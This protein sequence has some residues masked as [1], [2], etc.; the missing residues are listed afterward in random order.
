MKVCNKAKYVL[1]RIYRATN[2]KAYLTKA[3]NMYRVFSIGNKPWSFSWDDKRAGVQLMLAELT[4]K[5]IYVQAIQRFLNGW[6]PRHS[7]K[8]TPRG[9]AWRDKWGP[10]RYAANTAFLALVAADIGIT[11]VIYRS[12]AKKQIHYMLGDGGRSFV[13]G[14][15]KNPPQ[16]PHHRS[17]SCPSRPAPCNWSNFNNPGPNPKV[18]YGALVGGPNQYDKYTDSRKDH[19]ANEV[20]TDYNA[21]FQSAVAGLKSLQLRGI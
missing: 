7:V 6:L 11:P 8:Y 20:A 4:K 9:L 17:S 21:G 5:P 16:R 13:V 1:I 18:L 14:F 10:N 19:V 12:F 3:E 15:G 2:N